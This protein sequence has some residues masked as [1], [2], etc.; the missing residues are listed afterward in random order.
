VPYIQSVRA[1]ALCKLL[2]LLARNSGRALRFS[3]DLLF[4]S[5]HA[6]TAHSR[7]YHFVDLRQH[8]ELVLA[9]LRF[10]VHVQ[11]QCVKRS[12]QCS[13]RLTL[14]AFA[15]L[16]LSVPDRMSLAQHIYTTR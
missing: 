4:V 9:V 1:I 11:L 10:V 15:V 14:L 13:G 12:D 6:S 16:H 5:T 7:V 3:Y 2:Q 8:T